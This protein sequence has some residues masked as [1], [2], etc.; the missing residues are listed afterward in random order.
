MLE[1]GKKRAANLGFTDKDL[2]WQVGDAQKLPFDDNTFDAYTISFGTTN[3]KAPRNGNRMFFSTDLLG[4]NCFV[5]C[6]ATAK[7]IARCKH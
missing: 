1:V 6:K 5:N 7:W 2:G 4:S 3:L